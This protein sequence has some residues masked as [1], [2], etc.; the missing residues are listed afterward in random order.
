MYQQG[1]GLSECNKVKA[2]QCHLAS[3]CSWHLYYN[4]IFRILW[5]SAQML[6]KIGGIGTNRT[7]EIMENDQ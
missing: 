5:T 7:E 2:C 6:A 4:I 1:Q 3:K